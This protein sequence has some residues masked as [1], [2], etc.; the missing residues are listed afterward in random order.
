[1]IRDQFRDL[2]IEGWN[3]I[4]NIWLYSFDKD[5]VGKYFHQHK[6]ITSWIVRRVLNHD[7]SESHEAMDPGQERLPEEDE[8]AIWIGKWVK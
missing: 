4:F 8:T 6:G 7:F 3:T 5:L 2:E 1:M